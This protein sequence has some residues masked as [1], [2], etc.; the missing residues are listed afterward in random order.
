MLFASMMPRDK[1]LFVFGTHTNAFSGNIKALLLQED[2]SRYKKIFIGK[3]KKIVLTARELDI[4]S[5]WKYSIKGIWYSLRAGIYVYS[6]YPSDIHFWLSSGAFYVN[7][8]HGTPL[9]KIERDVTTG[10]YALRNRYKWLFQLIVPYL[11]V[12]PDLL[13]V[14]SPYEKECFKSAFDVDDKVFLELFPPRLQ[15]MKL[16]SVPL[17]AAIKHKI[18]YAPTWRDDHSFQIET[19]MDIEKL[20]HYLKENDL[21]LY[22]KPHPSDRSSYDAFSKAENIYLASAEDDIYTLF[23]EC[24]ILMTDYSSMLFEALYLSKTV[25]LFCPDYKEYLKNN[26]TFYMD[27]CKDLSFRNA[28]NT[29]GLICMMEKIVTTRD[30]TEKLPKEIE[31]YNVS[32]HIIEQIYYRVSDDN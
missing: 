15:E 18:L 11:F 21:I 16:S 32:T 10:H 1:K 28:K 24:D 26:R 30:H 25:V 9:K 8:W 2:S 14:S 29:E 19:Y 27:P 20:D 3:N 4:E 13:F 12:K 22:C 5:Y 23:E 6:S 31:P 17:N 7:V